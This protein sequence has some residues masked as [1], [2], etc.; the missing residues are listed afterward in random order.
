MKL[1]RAAGVRIHSEHR[2]VGNP[3]NGCLIKDKEKKQ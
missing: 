1:G 3:Q 2:A